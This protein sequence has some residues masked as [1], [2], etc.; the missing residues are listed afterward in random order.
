MTVGS[1]GSFDELRSRLYLTRIQGKRP[2]SVKKDYLKIGQGAYLLVAREWSAWKRREM[3]H[4]AR[5]LWQSLVSPDSVMVL[6]SAA[7]VWGLP[8]SEAT[9]LVHLST[10]PTAGRSSTELRP[11]PGE[12]GAPGRIIRHSMRLE[13]S[14]VTIVEGIRV[15]TLERL[16]L[17]MGRMRSPRAAIVVIDA[18]LGRLC[19]ASKFRPEATRSRAE[20][21]RAQ[22]LER[23]GSMTR[24]PGVRRARELVRFADPLAESPKES[25]LRWVILA[26][27]LPSPQTQFP[28]PIHENDSIFFLDLWIKELGVG[29]EFDGMM[30]YDGDDAKQRLLNEKQRYLSL[31]A[32]G[33]PVHQIVNDNI[34]TNA[35]LRVTLEKTLGREVLAQY[36]PRPLLLEPGLV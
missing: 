9:G 31:R 1:S 28:V 27:G 17:D 6:E 22:L 10:P 24:F 35:A 12:H 19:N 32:A 25:E 36:R 2:A 30:K 4:L 16:I 34:R 3:I 20:E 5:I 23:L 18:A 14:D 8:L 15:C 26:L 11:L 7:A 33:F 13:E 29:F 21:I